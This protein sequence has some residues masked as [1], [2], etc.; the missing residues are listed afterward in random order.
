ME[1]GVALE[2][3][4]VL[5]YAHTSAL[6]FLCTGACCRQLLALR[7]ISRR[8]S[9]A[10]GHHLTLVL[11]RGRLPIC[12]NEDEVEQ[13]ERTVR[14]VHNLPQIHG[15]LVMLW[16]MIRRRARLRPVLRARLSVRQIAI[17]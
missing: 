11:G 13:R 9:S 17:L 4:V 14:L 16:E 2:E 8:W 7:G 3:Q 6:G 15:E 5:C 1:H 10:G 12:V